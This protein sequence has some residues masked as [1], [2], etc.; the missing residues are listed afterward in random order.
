MSLRIFAIQA[1]W[2]WMLQSHFL[3]DFAPEINRL[4]SSC[5]EQASSAQPSVLSQFLPSSRRGESEKNCFS[6]T[7]FYFYNS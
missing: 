6:L 3:M 1:R 2:A 7:F 5:P 4:V